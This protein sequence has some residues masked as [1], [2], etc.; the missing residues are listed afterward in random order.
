MAER[1]LSYRTDLARRRLARSLIQL[2][3]RLGEREADGSIRLLP[4]T[5]DLL[6]QYVATSRWIVTQCMIQFRQLDYLTYSR[7][8]IVIHRDRL[9]EEFRPGARRAISDLRV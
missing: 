8:D 1:V 4:L 7:R 3:D 6:A 2:A 5:H 9:E